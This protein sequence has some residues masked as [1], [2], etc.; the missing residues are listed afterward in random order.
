M[1]GAVATVVVLLLGIGIGGYLWFRASDEPQ[2]GQVTRADFDSLTLD[3]ARADVQ[4]LVGRNPRPRSA[5][6]LPPPPVGVTCDLYS[7]YPRTGN[8]AYVGYL[9]L[10]RLCYQADR[11]VF[12]ARYDGDGGEGCGV[13]QSKIAALVIPARCPGG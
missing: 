2:P 8:N 6:T 1:F 4:R 5:S 10:I 9:N 7:E 12:K 13:G 3:E 11:L